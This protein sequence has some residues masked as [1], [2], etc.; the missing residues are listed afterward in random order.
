MESVCSKPLIQTQLTELD[1]YLNKQ[2]L[3]RHAHDFL[4]QHDNLY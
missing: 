1:S 2:Q 3:V 4:I